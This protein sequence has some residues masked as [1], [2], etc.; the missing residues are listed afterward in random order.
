VVAVAGG[1]F[2]GSTI[3]FLRIW[4]RDCWPVE[5]NAAKPA[6]TAILR[7]IPRLRPSILRKNPTDPLT[8]CHRARSDTRATEIAA[9]SSALIDT[10]EKQVW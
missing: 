7:I 5:T 3:P 9:D 2:P 10:A 1:L 4:S 8:G 6:R